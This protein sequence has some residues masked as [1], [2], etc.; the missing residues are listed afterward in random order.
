MPVEKDQDPNLEQIREAVLLERSMAEKAADDGDLE[1]AWAHLQRAIGRLSSS[2]LDASCNALLIST[3]IE[4]QN[5]CISLG[6]GLATFAPL[7][8]RARAAAEAIGDRRSRALI[9]LHLGRFYNYHGDRNDALRYFEEG[10][11]EVEE[12]GDEDILNQSAE[13]LGF[14]FQIRGLY[15]DALPRFERAARMYESAEK[16]YQLNPLGPVSL[17]YCYAFLGRFHNAIGTLDYYRQLAIERADHSL[18]TTMQ[19]IKG[20]VLL[21]IDRKEEAYYE[22]HSAFQDA[23]KSRNDIA[24]YFAS[25][26]LSYYS[27]L[28]GDIQESW[29]ALSKHT[30]QGKKTGLN[31]QYESP[32]KIEHI[33]RLHSLGF[34]PVPGLDY[35]KEIRR[36]LREPNVHLRGVALRI[37][38]LDAAHGDEPHEVV[39]EKLKKSEELLVRSGDPI[40]LARTRLELARL[41]LRTHKKEEARNYA[42]KSWHGFS[43]YGDLFFPDNMRYLLTSGGPDPASRQRREE[44]TE[45]F[46]AMIQYLTPSA[47]MDD[48]MAKTVKATNR[49]FGAERGALFWFTGRANRRKPTLRGASNLNRRE[50]FSKEFKPNLDLIQTAFQENRPQIVRLAGGEGHWPH[51]TRAVLCLPFEVS[52]QTRGVLYHDNSYGKDC[53][54]FL[55]KPMLS[56]LGSFLSDYIQQIY[57]F[58]R[59]LEQAATE[60]IQ[61]DVYPEKDRIIARS[62][63]MKR[64]LEQTDRVAPSDGNVVILGE[65]G[66]GKE[67]L[68]HRIHHMSGR[69]A[70][71]FVVV[72]ATT[73]PSELFESELFGYERGAFTG[74]NRSK[75]GRLELAH[76]GTLFIDEIGEI[77]KPLQVKLLRVLQEKTLIRLG[78][79]RTISSNFRLVVATN[80]DL[81]AEVSAGHFREDLYFRLNVVPITLPPLRE[82]LEDLPLLARHFLGRYSAK[83]NRP[84]PEL[85]P[86]DEKRLFEY[87]WPGNIRELQNVMERAMI[88]STDGDLFIDLPAEKGTNTRQFYS[89]LPTMDEMQRRYIRYAIA[90]T[91]GKIGGPGGAAELLG[92]KRTTLQKRMQKLNL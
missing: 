92:M 63:V 87:H 64:I 22:L 70:G 80:R 21:I 41:K 85:S 83:Y 45:K 28:Q 5:I 16:G 79:K 68:A 65:T 26:Y 42:Q 74:A 90:K 4:F 59:R 30:R 6:K 36:Y 61:A 25:G 72:D 9:L 66:V 75:A 23:A 37:Q 58:S 69:Q 11:S 73:I 8:K 43:G 57:D 46:I 20:M 54:D 12:L 17:A 50:V 31:R 60:K 1:S 24:Y 39:F 15:L 34:K 56:R 18:A 32:I 88:L 33:H 52:G 84:A 29:D 82:R 40:Q 38:A 67:L 81:A 71:P 19:A 49:F 76:N 86:E 2:D 53:F 78:G 51:L 89:D 55:E 14:Y 77:P 47:D 44:L 62:A 91:G 3:T 48:M 13:L 10:K 7:L 35:D 27:L